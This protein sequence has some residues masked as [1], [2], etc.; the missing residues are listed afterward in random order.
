MISC[1]GEGKG[2]HKHIAGCEELY[3]FLSVEKLIEDFKVDIYKIRRSE[4]D[5][6]KD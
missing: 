3:K 4:S 6:Q 5:K 2:D 1:Q